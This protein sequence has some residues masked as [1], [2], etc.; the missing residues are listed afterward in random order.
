M[1]VLDRVREALA[2]AQRAKDALTAVTGTIADGREAID[3]K[4]LDQMQELLKKEKLETQA[5]ADDLA[6]AIADYRKAHG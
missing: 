3:T 5:A 6:K 1:N 2:L 4:R